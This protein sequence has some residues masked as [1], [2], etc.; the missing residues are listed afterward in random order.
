MPIAVSRRRFITFV[1]A[2]AGLPLL[3]KAGGAQ[4]RLV[5]WDGTALGGPA[6]IQLYHHNESVAQQA[7]AAALVELRRLEGIFSVYRAD[8]AI[9]RLNRQG[10]LDQAPADLLTMLQRALFLAKISDGVYDPTVQPLWNLY[11]S[12]FNAANPDPA[13]PSAQARDAALALVDWRSVEVDHA[14]QRIA[15][16]RPGMGLTLNAGAQGY[17][18]DRVADQLRAHGFDRMLVDMGEPRVLSTKPDGSAWR[19][20]IAN[21]ADRNETVTSLDVV[22]K[23]IATSG[24]Y[25]TILDEA[26][27]FTHI[28]DTRTGATAPAMS[29][30]SVVAD[31]GMAAD[32]LSATMLMAPVDKRQAILQAGGGEQAIFVTP[33]GVVATVKA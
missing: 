25:G 28:F 23:C 20:G 7:I 33:Q 27:R 2:A 5:R 18:T 29:S 6:S 17:I 14:S 24:G 12:H 30:V 26:G 4:A 21:P 3:L 19:I 13:G 22:D 31:T 8:S 10:K 15:F 1:A 9:S 11:Y 32:G 16:A